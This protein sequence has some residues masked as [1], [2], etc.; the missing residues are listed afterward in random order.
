MLV[1][2]LDR[3]RPGLTLGQS[4]PA[5]I[6]CQLGRRAFGA[7]QTVELKAPIVGC[8]ACPLSHIEIEARHSDLSDLNGCL[9]NSGGST[10]FV[11][12]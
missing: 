3:H 7:I 1:R 4:V 2:Q 12:P 5:K 8:E 11:N 10:L 9:P 6:G